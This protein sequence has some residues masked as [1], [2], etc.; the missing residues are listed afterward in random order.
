MSPSVRNAWQLSSAKEHRERR[1]TFGTI[2]FSSLFFFLSL[3]LS[4]SLPLSLSLSLSLSWP[5]SNTTK[6]TRLF[7]RA[8]RYRALLLTSHR[9]M[10]QFIRLQRTPAILPARWAHNWFCYM[11]RSW[12]NHCLG[13]VICP[14]MR[15]FC[16]LANHQ[17]PGREASCKK[18]THRRTA[19]PKIH[20]S[21]T[22]G[23]LHRNVS[24][25]ENYTSAHQHDK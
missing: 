10:L 20:K 17:A 7:L 22:I 1:D 12:W 4:L 25:E 13:K 24:E 23:T 3:S 19:L 2:V 8:A 15:T 9:T 21:V 14:D 16:E 5:G 18:A 6:N 11:V